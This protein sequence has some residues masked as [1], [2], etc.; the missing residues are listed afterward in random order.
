MVLITCACAPLTEQQKFEREDRMNLVIE[1]FGRKEKACRM[2]G[3]TMQ[4]SVPPLAK[5]G[6]HDYRTAKCV[7]L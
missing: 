5:A 2:V 1:E 7:R 4:F 6:Y 3:G